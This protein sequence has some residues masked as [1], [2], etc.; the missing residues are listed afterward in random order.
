MLLNYSSNLIISNDHLSAIEFILYQKVCA[1]LSLRFLCEVGLL[2]S[3]EE[4]RVGLAAPPFGYPTRSCLALRATAAASVAPEPSWVL[5]L[6]ELGGLPTFAMVGTLELGC[7]PDDVWDV[8]FGTAEV[9]IVMDFGCSP[10]GDCCFNSAS[11]ATSL[12][13]PAVGLGSLSIRTD[14]LS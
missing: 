14:A 1:H 9:F 3:F 13:R 12:A 7:L 5:M 8:N 11:S 6:V 10:V 4:E 2:G